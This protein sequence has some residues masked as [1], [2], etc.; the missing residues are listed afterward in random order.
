MNESISIAS[1]SSASASRVNE[2][3]HKLQRSDE[4]AADLQRQLHAA[5][6]S[7]RSGGAR[8]AQVESERDALERSVARYVS[9]LKV[10]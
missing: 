5:E 2:L 10:L 3:R 6:E 7:L 8:S 4:R 9:E 1:P